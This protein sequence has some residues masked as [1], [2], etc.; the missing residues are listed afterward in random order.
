MPSEGGGLPGD[1]DGDFIPDEDDLCPTTPHPTNHDHDGDLVGD[2]CDPCPADPANADSDGDDVGDACERSNGGI[3][4]RLAFF[5]FYDRVDL[6]GWTNKDKVAITAQ[7][8]A[9][10]EAVG[11]LNVR[12]VAPITATHVLVRTRMHVTQ[13]ASGID[14]YAGIVT[15]Y[16][17]A[18]EHVA[19]QLVSVE[20]PG[21]RAVRTRVFIGT[22]MPLDT[23]VPYG[24]PPTLGAHDVVADIVGS[25]LACRVQGVPAM[26]SATAARGAIG[27]EA[28]SMNI[29][30]DYM[31][32]IQQPTP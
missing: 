21:D 18:T 17:N 11:S 24:G 22:T 32:I 5:G 12:A 16:V 25:S 29:E 13:R 4:T 9:R 15:R 23:A 26:A 20:E 8:R 30:V 7:G 6:S 19:C 27:L 10:L 2:V 31:D 1:R 3:E 28:G 14:V